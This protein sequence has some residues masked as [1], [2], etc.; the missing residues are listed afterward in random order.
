MLR[1]DVQAVQ[2]QLEG[3]P[4][5][6]ARLVGGAVAT[7]LQSAISNPVTWVTLFTMLQKE[8]SE[9]IGRFSLNTIWGM[10]RWIM[11]FMALGLVVYMFGGWSAL[12]AFLKGAWLALFG[13][14]P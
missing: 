9:G 4:A 12:S 13:P 8:A 3:L 6:I 1:A 14:S 11:K 10:G 7:G 2:Q 5:E